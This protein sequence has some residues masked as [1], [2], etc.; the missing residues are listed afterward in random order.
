[1]LL[2]LG[3]FGILD[4]TGTLAW[5]QMVSQWWPLAIIGF[6]LAVMVEG[7]CVSL[8]SATITTIGLALLMDNQN[9][10]NKDARNAVWSLLLASVGLAVLFGVGL[11]GKP[12]RRDTGREGSRAESEGSEDRNDHRAGKEA[13]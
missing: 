7:R 9:W 2:A 4:V 8:G 3:T 1:M 6:G 12:G 11:G 10:W 5:G 13:A